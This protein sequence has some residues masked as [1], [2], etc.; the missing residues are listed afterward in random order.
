VFSRRNFRVEYP[1]TWQIVNFAKIFLDLCTTNLRNFC[2]NAQ[3]RFALLVW[4]ALNGVDE[5]ERDMD[6]IGRVNG[7]E[8]GV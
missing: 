3:G 6:E 7:V 4:M 1:V 5:A 2:G 8:R